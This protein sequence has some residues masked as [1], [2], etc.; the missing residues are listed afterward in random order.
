MPDAQLFRLR[1][2][3]SDLEEILAFLTEGVA[4][5][6]MK[7]LEKKQL[8]IRVVPFMLI[9]G[10]LHNLGC[11]KVLHRCVLEHECLTIIEEAHRGSA[12]G[13]YA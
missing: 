6:G 12:G 9:S 11:D 10:D 13:Y 3:L 5:E 1:H 8:A 4:P 2:T 7:T